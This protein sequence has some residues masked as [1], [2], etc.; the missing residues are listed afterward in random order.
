MLAVTVISTGLHFSKVYRFLFYIL[1]SEEMEK[2]FKNYTK[3]YLM[4]LRKQAGGKSTYNTIKLKKI[5]QEFMGKTKTSL[6]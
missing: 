2:H 3:V 4:T 5:Y 6:T 1:A